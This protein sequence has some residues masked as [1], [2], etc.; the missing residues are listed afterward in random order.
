MVRRAFLYAENIFGIQK[1]SLLSADANRIRS[2]TGFALC[3]SF[4]PA[5]RIERCAC[6]R[7]VS[8][9]R[10][11][12]IAEGTARDGQWWTWDRNGRIY[13]QLSLIF[14]F[15]VPAMCVRPVCKAYVRAIRDTSIHCMRSMDRRVSKRSRS[16]ECIHSLYTL[17]EYNPYIHNLLTLM[18]LP[19]TTALLRL[20]RLPSFCSCRLKVAFFNGRSVSSVYL[21]VVCCD[22]TFKIFIRSGIRSRTSHCRR[23]REARSDRRGFR[24]KIPEP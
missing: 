16:S 10:W 18:M 4:A 24:E 17:N 5:H 21:G 7:R 2:Q 3:R 20:S 9:H 8:D 14:L 15:V 13:G 12:R 23:Q 19:W 22:M 1:Y 11:S 6:K